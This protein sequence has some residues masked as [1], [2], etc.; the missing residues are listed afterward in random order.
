MKSKKIIVRNVQQLEKSIQGRRNC[1]IYIT[2]NCAK[3]INQ[4]PVW[5]YAELM[6]DLKCRNIGLKDEEKISM[7]N[8]IDE[9]IEVVNNLAEL[10]EDCAVHG[11]DDM[12]VDIGFTQKEA[13]AIRNVVNELKRIS[14]F[15]IDNLIED[16][17]T[18]Q[19]I[20]KDK[21]LKII[22]ELNI[23]IERNK[24][25]EISNNTE[26]NLQMT[27]ISYDPELVKMRLV[28]LLE[29]E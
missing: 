3:E 14:S 19:F 18:G 13:T 10:Y 29:E 16:Y 25:R 7:S 21:I 20:H 6:E 27:L 22:K 12:R 23:D 9:D 28:K 4:M 15:D 1:I 17:E 11:I 24:R 5:R 2:Y 26:E 8:N